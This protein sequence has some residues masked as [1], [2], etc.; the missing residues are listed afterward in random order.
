MNYRKEI[1]KFVLQNFM[2]STDE[3]QLSDSESLLQ[4]G[5]VDSTG[6]LE[7]IA[8]LEETYGIRVLDE[9]MLPENLDSINSIADFVTRKRPD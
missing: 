3:S 1:K 7:L 6:I 4:R 8:H 5:I 9:E 2:F